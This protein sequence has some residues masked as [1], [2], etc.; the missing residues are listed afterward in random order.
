MS[1]SRSNNKSSPKRTYNI[2][3]FA[4]I[5]WDED[6][7]VHELFVDY[8][9]IKDLDIYKYFVSKGI[10]EGVIVKLTNH[11][12]KV[13]LQGFTITD[14]ENELTRLE[15]PSVIHRLLIKLAFDSMSIEY[16]VISENFNMVSFMMLLTNYKQ[17]KRD[18]NYGEVRKTIALMKEY[19]ISDEDKAKLTDDTVRVLAKWGGESNEDVDEDNDKDNN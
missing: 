15:I 16:N 11:L 12:K 6:D 4:E 3:K 10:E 7:N 9:T 17:A 13:V 2:A 14:L 5:Q 1:T 18:F 19:K 8:K